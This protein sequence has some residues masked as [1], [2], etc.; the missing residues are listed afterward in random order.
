MAN[1]IKIYIASCSRQK[2]EFLENSLVEGFT[3]TDKANEA[4]LIIVDLANPE[5]KPKWAKSCPLIL[6]AVD[7]PEDPEALKATRFFFPKFFPVQKG[8]E[9][10]KKELERALAYAQEF[11]TLKN[12]LL[13]QHLKTM[14]GQHG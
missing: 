6:A 9:E 13:M 8:E 12:D 3:F 11:L 10:L 2:F 1:L 14:E 7:G 4:D 5:E